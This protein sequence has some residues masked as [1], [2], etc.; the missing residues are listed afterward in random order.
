MERRSE[1]RVSA[2]QKVSLTMLGEN[3]RE[4]D[5]DAIELSGCGMRIRIPEPAR[6]GEAVKIYL[7][8]ALL[9]GEICYCWPDGAWFVIGVE[10]REALSGLKDLAKLN[11]ALLGERVK[12]GALSYR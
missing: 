5:G 10:V 9:L 4:M 6:T 1:V 11:R 3:G 8:D 7:Q 12:E 2:N